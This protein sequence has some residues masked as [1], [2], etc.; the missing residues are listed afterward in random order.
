M[1]PTVFY[2]TVISEEFEVTLYLPYAVYNDVLRY[3]NVSNP[4]HS[5]DC[6]QTHHTLSIF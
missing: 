4:L 6:I 2:Y 5:N 1:L 3:Y